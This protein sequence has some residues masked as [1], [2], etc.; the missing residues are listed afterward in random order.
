MIEPRSVPAWAPA[1]DVVF[2]LLAFVAAMVAASG[3]CRAHFRGLR[4]AVTSPLPLLASYLQIV[5]EEYRYT[6][7]DRAIQQNI[8][9]FPAYPILIRV[10]GRL[11]SGEMTGCVVAGMLVSLVSFFWRPLF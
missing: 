8:V 7:H 3:G 6:S 9:F 10:V 5:T 4:V 11:F 1:L 2:L